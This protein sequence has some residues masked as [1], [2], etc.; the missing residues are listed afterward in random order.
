[1]VRR[2]REEREQPEGSADQ[3]DTR[4]SG[5][6]AGIGEVVP[7]IATGI[8]GK[9]GLPGLDMDMPSVLCVEGRGDREEGELEEQQPNKRTR[10]SKTV[11]EATG[12]KP[13]D[14]EKVM[15]RIEAKAKINKK[16]AAWKVVADQ[17]DEEAKER[18]RKARKEFMDKY[19]EPRIPEQTVSSMDD[20]LR[21]FL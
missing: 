21:I 6:C 10:T 3:P 4:A 13:T 8:E 12:A 20:T 5:V 11:D 15:A 18:K 1:M 19:G 2:T 17:M 16:M 7:Q 14:G 9:T